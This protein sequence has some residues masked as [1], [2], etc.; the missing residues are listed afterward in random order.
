MKIFFPLPPYLRGHSFAFWGTFIAGWT[1]LP[2]REALQTVAPNT[3]VIGLFITALGW[4]GL[5]IIVNRTSLRIER[6]DWLWVLLIGVFSY[7]ANYCAAQALLLLSPTIVMTLQRGEILIAMAL[8]WLCFHERLTLTL[9]L[10]MLLVLL[11]IYVC[12][13]E[14]CRSLGQIGILLFGRLVLQ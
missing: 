8:G 13:P 9:W 2:Y 7:A 14:V 5:F 1:A 4:N 6:K 12:N 10:G 11:G 3:A